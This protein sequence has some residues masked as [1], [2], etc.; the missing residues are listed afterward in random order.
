[1]NQRP[2]ALSEHPEP[3]Q[4]ALQRKLEV[5]IFGTGTPAGRRFDMALIAVILMSVIVVIL[6]LIPELDVP[7]DVREQAQRYEW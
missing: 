3:W 7:S 6:D 5:C 4:N 1:M 2:N